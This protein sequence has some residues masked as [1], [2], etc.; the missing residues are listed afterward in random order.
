[1]IYLEISGAIWSGVGLVLVYG[2]FTRRKWS[3]RMAQVAALT[4]SAYYWMD[5]LFIAKRFV[6]ENRWQFAVVL[7]LFLV[8]VTFWTL[9][10]PKTRAFVNR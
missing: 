7:N 4:Y 9:Q 8:I 2:F 6:I 5:K 3:L 1:V 10:Q